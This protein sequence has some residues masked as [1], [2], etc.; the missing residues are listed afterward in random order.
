MAKK[1]LNFNIDGTSPHILP[2][3]RLAEYLRELAAVLGSQEGVHFLRVG[4]GSAACTMEVDEDEEAAII[5]R[6]QGV[7]GRHA[8]KEAI[9][10][11]ESLRALLQ[12]DEVSAELE[13]DSGEVILDFS[14]PSDKQEETFGPF[15]Q[16]G[17]LDGILVKIGGLDE[18]IPVHLINEGSHYICNATKEVARQLAHRLYGSPIRVHGRGKWYRNAAGQWEMRWFNIDRFEDLDSAS[19]PELVARLRA[20]PDNPLMF[21]KDPIA[22][23][24]KVRHGDE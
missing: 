1:E 19:L 9:K 18:T 2:M 16:D 5:A 24:L 13:L 23:I 10:A 22:E 3:A 17:A 6:V 21:L 14:L 11:Y 20:I 4:E 12:K 8:P 7:T 15:W